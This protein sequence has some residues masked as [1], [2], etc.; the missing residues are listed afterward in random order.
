MNKNIS[1]WRG[2]DPPPTNTHVW[3]KP[4]RTINIYSKGQWINVSSNSEEL[5]QLKQYILDMFAVIV[6]EDQGKSIR[7]IVREETTDLHSW[8]DV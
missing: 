7:D 1:V 2:I 8:I 5:E 4:N 6:D 3:I